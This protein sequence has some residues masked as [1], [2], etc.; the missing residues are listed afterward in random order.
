MTK[1]LGLILAISL[2]C[3]S[4]IA[5]GC[6][7][8]KTVTQTVNGGIITVPGVTTTLPAVTQT[9]NGGIITVPG[10]TTTLPA[11]TVTLPS[12]VVT[13]IPATVVTAPPVTTTIASPTA[14]TGLFLLPTTP[15]SIPYGMTLNMAGDCLFCHAKGQYVEFPTPPVWDGTVANYTNYNIYNVI[16]GSIQDHSGRK[17]AECLN[18]HAVSG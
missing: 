18:C 6:S 14:P 10:G 15:Q 9:V 12:Q 5:V 7:S 8:A 2:I 13:T 16:A 3:V 17:N 4:T 1:K 11:V